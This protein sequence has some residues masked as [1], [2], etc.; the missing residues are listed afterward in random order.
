MPFYQIS[1]EKKAPAFANIDNIKEK[2]ENHFGRIYE[3][4]DDFNKVI[5][6]EESFVPIGELVNELTILP[7]FV[8]GAS[9]IEPSPFW[10]YFIIY[11]AESL[12]LLA[13]ATV[14]EAH[15]TAVMFR[16]KI[17]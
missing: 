5:K 13:Y 2:F 12:D 6:D 14:Y 10:Q 7:F 9:V 8:D 1:F 17:S 3:N 4:V 11:D 15:L 16:A